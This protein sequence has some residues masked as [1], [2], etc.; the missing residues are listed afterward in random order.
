MYSCVFVRDCVYSYLSLEVSIHSIHMHI[1]SK[2]EQGQRL[3]EDN[4]A[5]IAAFGLLPGYT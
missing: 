4:Q 2:S 1:I 3:N 5:T